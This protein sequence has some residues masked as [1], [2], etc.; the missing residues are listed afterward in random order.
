MGGRHRARRSRRPR[1]PS[2]NR[3]R[4]VTVLALIAAALSLIGQLMEAR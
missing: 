3:A 2:V 4:V 1:W